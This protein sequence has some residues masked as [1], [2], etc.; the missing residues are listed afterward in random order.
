MTWLRE[1]ERK[2][3]RDDPLKLE[4]GELKMGLKF[5]KVIYVGVVCLYVCGLTTITYECAYYRP[6][7]TDNLNQV[8]FY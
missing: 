4:E 6:L 8:I 7:P 2:I 3:Q 5:L 1:T